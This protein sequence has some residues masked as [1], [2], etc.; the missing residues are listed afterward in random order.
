MYALLWVK[1]H[2]RDFC[3]EPWASG[4]SLPAEGGVVVGGSSGGY[5]DPKIVFPP[6]F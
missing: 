6:G 1:F 3:S 2:A 5:D 4:A